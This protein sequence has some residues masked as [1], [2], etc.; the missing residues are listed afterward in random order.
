[1]VD[2]VEALVAL[3]RAYVEVL[4]RKDA[5]CGD[6]PDYR[7]AGD[8][9]FEVLVGAVQRLADERAPDL[10]VLLGSQ[11]CWSS[12]QGLVGLHPTMVELGARHGLD[13]PAIGELAERFTRQLVAGL[14]P[15]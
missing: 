2:P 11:L 3:G 10:D 9:A 12:M 15:C 4:F 7:A 8:A 14:V 13:V 6:S 5:L 1:M